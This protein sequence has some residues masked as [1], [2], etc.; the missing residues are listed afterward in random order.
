M[1]ITSAV[2]FAALAFVGGP[3]F[4]QNHLP[5]PCAQ[6]DFPPPPAYYCPTP[7][8]ELIPENGDPVFARAFQCS[9]TGLSLG[10]THN[11]GCGSLGTL[12]NWLVPEAEVLDRTTSAIVYLDLVFVLFDDFL[13][14]QRDGVFLS[15]EDIAL[16][17]EIGMVIPNDYRGSHAPGGF[18][19]RSPG[20]DWQERLS[21]LD[22][23]SYEDAEHCVV[24]PKNAETD[25][26]VCGSELALLVNAVVFN[27]PNLERVVN[28]LWLAKICH[29][30]PTACP[31]HSEY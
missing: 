12:E 7:Y 4:A 13:Q 9:E 6:L 19:A 2:V 14:M 24:I 31:L 15:P 8:V 30:S 27:G 23:P 1:R 3:T 28:R 25:T 11:G 29:E 16:Y 26:M 21:R 10:V 20:S 17:R 22:D 5:E 18:F